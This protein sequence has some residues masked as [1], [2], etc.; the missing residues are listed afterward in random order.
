L[1]GLTG[2]VLGGWKICHID[3][4]DPINAMFHPS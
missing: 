4:V 3:V 1:E 2:R